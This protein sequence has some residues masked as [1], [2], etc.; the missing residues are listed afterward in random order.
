MTG[1]STLLRLLY[2][3]YSPDAGS[4]SV[5]GRV[6][7]DYTQDSLRRAIAVVPQDTVLFHESIGYNI[8]Y[9]NLDASWDDVVEAA[10]KASINLSSGLLRQKDL[11]T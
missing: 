8:H 3:F 7:D 10:K 6:L 9:G 2:R 4:I 11:R 1:K 5:G